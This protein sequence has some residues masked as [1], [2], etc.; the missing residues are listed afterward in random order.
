MDVVCMCITLNMPLFLSK[1]TFFYFLFS[2]INIWQSLDQLSG[3]SQLV[4]GK[5]HKIH[6]KNFPE[7][8]EKC[9]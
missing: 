8:S 1:V 2:F 4:T 3:G 9:F 7:I 5:R 6:K